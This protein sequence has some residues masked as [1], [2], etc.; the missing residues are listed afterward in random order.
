MLID[1]RLAITLSAVMSQWLVLV[2]E[3]VL[4]SRH[5]SDVAGIV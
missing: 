5:N 4:S 2:S 3:P 1:E